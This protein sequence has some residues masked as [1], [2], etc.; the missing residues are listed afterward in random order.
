MSNE[1]I[2][3][4]LVSQ[5]NNMKYEPIFEIETEDGE[6]HVYNISASVKGLELGGVANVGFHSYGLEI[7][8]WDVN[9]GLDE[10]L[11]EL[12]EIAYEDAMNGDKL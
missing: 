1:T 3:N 5:F 9:F 11:Q 4:L 7:V 8:E 6:F 10:H 12:Y 2:K